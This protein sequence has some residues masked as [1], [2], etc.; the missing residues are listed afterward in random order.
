M[1]KIVEESMLDTSAF[2]GLIL[3]FVD[4]SAYNNLNFWI[5]ENRT[6]HLTLNG[7]DS[8]FAPYYI[9]DELPTHYYIRGLSIQNIDVSTNSKS[10]YY[11]GWEEQITESPTFSPTKLPTTNPT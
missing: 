9:G 6:I 2:S 7:D 11:N 10:I 1:G 4:L 8:L 3:N 5:N